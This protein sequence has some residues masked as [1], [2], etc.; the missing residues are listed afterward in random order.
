MKKDTT[1][2]ITNF[3]TAKKRIEAERAEDERVAAQDR[4]RGKLQKALEEFDDETK[5]E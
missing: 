3:K 4:L 2:N 1:K 5:G